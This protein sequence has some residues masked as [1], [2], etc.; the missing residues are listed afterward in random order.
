MTYLRRKSGLDISKGSLLRVL[1][2]NPSLSNNTHTTYTGPKYKL[3]NDFF[4][5]TS[6]VIHWCK[7]QCMQNIAES[8]DN[9]CKKGWGTSREIDWSQMH[10]L[11]VH[12]AIPLILSLQLQVANTLAKYPKRSSVHSQTHAEPHRAKAVAILHY[13]VSSNIT[14]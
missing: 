1:H 9:I 14:G 12:M 2:T 4:D 3:D 6:T 8:W 7:H 5:I 10:Q 13:P 11:M